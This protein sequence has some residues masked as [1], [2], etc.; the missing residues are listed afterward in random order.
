[1]T[2][3]AVINPSKKTVELVQA[4]GMDAALMQAG[5]KSGEV[6]WGSIGRTTDKRTITIVA[7]EFGLRDDMAGDGWVEPNYTRIGRQMYAGNLLVMAADN[8]GEDADVTAKDVMT[9]KNHLE[10]LPTRQDCEDAMSR[11]A[12]DRPQMSVNGQVLWQ[13][14]VSEN[15]EEV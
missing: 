13:W 4:E 6:D 12:M 5:L 3:Y 7:Y 8:M 15:G 10:W 2:Q 1:M 9:L 11:G 14:N